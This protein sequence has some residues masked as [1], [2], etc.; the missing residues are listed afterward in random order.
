M[1]LPCYVAVEGSG[2]YQIWRIEDKEELDEMREAEERF[3]GYEIDW[4]DHDGLYEIGGWCN[5]S[6]VFTLFQTR[7]EAIADYEEK[8]R[9]YK[10]EDEIELELL[11]YT[12]EE[13]KKK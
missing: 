13:K 2:E 9:I 12:H 1:R 3:R 6:Y 4:D 11:D 5:G 7:E 10:E 8:K